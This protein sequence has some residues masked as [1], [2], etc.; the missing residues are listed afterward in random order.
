MAIKRLDTATCYFTNSDTQKKFES[1]EKACEAAEDYCGNG[2]YT[3]PF[4]E[5]ET[6][7]YGPGDGT[8]SVMVRQDISF[9]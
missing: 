7:L 9:V 5:E 3:R 6:R 2:V 8:T 4:P 1:F